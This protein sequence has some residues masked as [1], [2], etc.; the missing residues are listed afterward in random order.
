QEFGVQTNS[1]SAEFGRL[2]GGVINLVTKSGTN[3]LRGTAFE[4]LRNSALDANNFFSNR[5]GIAKGSFRRNQFG[6]NVGGPIRKNR[7][8]FFVNYEGLRQGAA[9]VGTFTVPLAEWRRGDFSNLKT[10][11]GQPIIIYDPLT[12]RR[13]PTN[14]SRFIRDPFPN[15]IIRP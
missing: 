9:N 10:A 12:T 4:F 2:G 5:A 8:F 13:D 7:T 1:V 6:G 14:P 15:N 3:R 11:S